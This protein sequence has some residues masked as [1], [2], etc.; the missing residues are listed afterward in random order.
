MSLLLARL[1][2]DLQKYAVQS[3][4]DLN[5]HC[6]LDEAKKSLEEAEID[7]E[8]AGSH[9]RFLPKRHDCLRSSWLR[10]SL[11]AVYLSVVF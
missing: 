4:C 2:L 6:N 5:F 10:F 1:I 7:P 11:A 8:G 9:Y 3:E